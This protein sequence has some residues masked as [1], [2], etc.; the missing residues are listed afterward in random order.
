MIERMR[1]RVL[2][3]SSRTDRESAMR[4]VGVTYCNL[5]SAIVLLICWL[6]IVPQQGSAQAPAA[7]KARSS[8]GGKLA[9]PPKWDRSVRD[10][11]FSDARAKL[12]PGPAP[13]S[14]EATA[15]ARTAAPVAATATPS[16]SAEKETPAA[17]PQAPSEPSAASW[18]ALISAETLEDEVKAQVNP[19]AAAVQSPTAFKGKGH[20]TARQDFSLLAVLFAV[21]GQ[22][23]AQVRWQAEAPSLRDLFARAGF[24]CKAATD[25]SFNEAKRRS[26]DLAE[27]V[28][29]GAVETRPAEADFEWPAIA[30]RPP[31]MKRMEQSLRERLDPWTASDRDFAKNRAAI[32]H[33]AQ[34]LAVLARVIKSEGYDYAEDESYRKYIDQLEQQCLELIDACKTSTLPK[35]QSATRLLNK[36]CDACHGEYR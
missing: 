4:G 26:Q 15:A 1:G 32:E 28:R 25:S 31:L 22:Y 27:L 35:A 12:G 34:L 8:R 7:P 2:P 6:A 33:E 17:S 23:D 20:E 11:F 21:I 14:A 36:T 18:S 3:R 24:N 19:L 13:G 30:N 10:T 29:G 16:S 5:R 9:P